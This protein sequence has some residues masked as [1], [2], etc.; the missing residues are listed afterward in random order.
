MVGLDMGIL[1]FVH[2]SD[3]LDVKPPDLEFLRGRVE[4]EQRKLSRKEYGSA[5][6]EKQRVN[7]ARAKRR[8]KRVVRDFHRK[9]ANWLTS[10]YSI[11]FIEDLDIKEM[12]EGTQS[13]RNKQ[14]LAWGEFRKILAHAGNKNGA[15]VVPVDPAGTTLRCAGCQT[16]VW[17]PLWIREHS[18]PTC[19]LEV[20]RDR[21]AG[22]N[23]LQDSVELVNCGGTEADTVSMGIFDDVDVGQGLSEVTPAETAAAVPANDDSLESHVAS[24]SSVIETGKPVCEDGSPTLKPAASAD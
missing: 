2:T 11:I 6:W 8:L 9:L 20:D 22:W 21:N 19:G 24:A 4:R 3:G 12:F 15:H 23:V 13:A 10:T 17:K 18:C 5:N 14:D 7:V 16:S 1:S